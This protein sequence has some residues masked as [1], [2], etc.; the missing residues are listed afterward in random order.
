MIAPWYPS[1][2]SK[3]CVQENM[4]GVSYEE[5]SCVYPEVR[6]FYTRYVVW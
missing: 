6:P 3:A 4:A 2:A 5:F 1:D